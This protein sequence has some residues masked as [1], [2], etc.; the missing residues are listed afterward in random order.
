MGIPWGAGLRKP[1]RKGDTGGR[2]ERAE[3][4]EE[5]ELEHELRE[6]NE[7]RK[8]VRKEEI[9]CRRTSAKKSLSLPGFLHA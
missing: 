4:K 9:F 7:L 6:I 3:T 1:Q 5:K 8:G 2:G